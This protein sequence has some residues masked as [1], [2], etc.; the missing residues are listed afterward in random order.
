[1]LTSKT[2]DRSAEAARFEAMIALGS[3]TLHEAQEQTGAMTGLIRPLVEEMRLAGPAFTVSAH[4]GDNLVIHYAI[5]RAPAGSVLVVDAGGFLEAGV[6]GDILTD[7]AKARGLIGLV[8]DGAVRDV[9]AICAIGFPVFARGVS[10]K[11][12]GKNYGGEV[13][14]T[15]SCGGAVVRNGDIIVG[16]RDGVVVLDADRIDE[17]MQ[18]AEARTAREASVRQAI[19]EGRTTVD[20]MN[21]SPLL[22]RVGLK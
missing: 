9:E 16:D 14:R 8:V 3:A 6:W 18:R 10:I 1:M 21:L 7:A 17:T 13:G 15:I 5:A 2:P 12:P 11:G 22:E 4:P 20:L 19:R